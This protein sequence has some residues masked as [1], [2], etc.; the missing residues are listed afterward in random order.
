MNIK[1]A[2]IG[3]EDLAKSICAHLENSTEVEIIGFYDD[4]KEK[5]KTKR[6]LG[7]TAQILQNFKEGIFTHIICAVGYNHLAYRKRIWEEFSGKIPFFTFVHS[8]AFLSPNVVVKEGNFIGPGCTIDHGVY[9]GPNNYFNPGCT[10][11]HDTFV[12]GH[13]FFSPSVSVAGF[14]KIHEECFLGIG[15]VVIDNIEIKNQVTIGA[16][17]VI[18]KS[19]QASGVYVGVPAKKIIK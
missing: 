17:A 1:L 12:L 4:F 3:S 13:S 14:V 16:G 19:V 10:I 7:N 9:V 2:L 15:S 11:G 18:T 8:T 5:C 6:I